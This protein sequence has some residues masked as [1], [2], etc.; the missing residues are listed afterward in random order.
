MSLLDGQLLLYAIL[1][2][3]TLLAVE[4]GYLYMRD[5][6]GAKKR[7]NKRMGLI[8]DGA[9]TDE[10]LSQLRR[11]PQRTDTRGIVA[12]LTAKLDVRLTQAGVQMP[13]QRLLVIMASVTAMIAVALPL[14][15]GF[16]GNLAMGSLLMTAIIAGFFGIAV[17][18][19]W[20]SMKANK[21]VKKFEQQF[22]VALDIFVR[23]LRAG[24]PVSAALSLLTSEMADPIGS[25]FGIVV[26]E[27]NY[28]LDLRSALENLA[29]R[30]RTPDIRMFV[31]CVAIQAETGGNLA[32][33]LEGLSRV[34][35]ERA[36][37]VLKV[38]ALA[39]EGK[40]TGIMLSV[41]PILTFITTFSAS[42]EF[43]L[44]T[45]DDPLF[46]PA[47]CGLGFLY[48]TGIFTIRKLVDLKV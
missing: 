7:I 14:V 29:E 36:S 17:P 3:A 22:P 25:E 1:F 11:A 27:V 47:A 18:M 19:I 44:K 41:L 9:S 46:M 34:I 21:R 40:M 45:V 4:G 2:V 33:I 15:L 42:P 39:S 16:A 26:D 35:R 6:R 32:E 38:R 28:G 8:G 12:K 24:H 31:V 48:V 30:L 23:G 20:L 10:V 37:M 13:A 43:Y 5:V